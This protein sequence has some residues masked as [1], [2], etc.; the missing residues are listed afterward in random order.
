MTAARPRPRRV[1]P[2]VAAVAIVATVLAGGGMAKRKT[3]PHVG[4]VLDWSNR[5]VLYPQGA[6]LRALA[7]GER[8]PRA[9][10]N[11][12]RLIQ[13]A[14]R[15]TP[16]SY[17]ATREPDAVLG[18]D[19]RD[20]ARSREAP[21][22]LAPRRPPM[23]PILPVRPPNPEV[24]WSIALAGAG[25][26]ANMFPAKYS[27]DVNATPD[28]TGD[29]VVFA[30]NANAT[31][32]RANIVALN[33]LYSGTTSTSCG[34]NQAASVLW[35]YDAGT[36]TSRIRTSP[37]ISLD[38]TK[39]AFIDGNNPAVFHVLTPTAGQGTITVPATPT[40]AQIA[41]VTLTTGADSNGSPFVD[42]Y[43]DVAYVA[44]NNG[45]IFK[46]TGVFNGTPALAGAPWPLT[47]GATTLTEPVI[48][49]GTGNIFVGSANGRLYGFTPAGV[50]IPGSPVIIGSGL[51]NGG[52]T[53]APLVD[54][55]NGLIYVATGDNAAQVNAVVAQTRTSTFATVSTAA[56]GNTNAAV[57][58]AGAFND[59]YFNVTTNMTGTTSEW[60][61]YE[62]GVSTGALTNPVL[63][64]L[65]FNAA[66]QI[67]AAV[68]A[69]SVSLS[70]NNGEVCSPI[71]EFKNGVDR[72]F[73]SLLTSAQV[74]FFDV[75]TTT[76]PTLGGT[77]AV[78]PVPQTGGTSG[79]I[80]DNSNSLP[81]ASSIYFT[82]LATGTCFTANVVAAPNGATETGNVVTITTTTAHG[83]GVG[84]S[85]T[86]AGVLVGYNGAHVVTSVPS[87]TKFTYTSATTGLANDGGGTATASGFCAVKLTQ[88]GLQ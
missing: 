46:I 43:G 8:D 78:S 18:R 44:T 7:V 21:V 15:A 88:G 24:D 61:L 58:H 42:Y 62:C 39:V 3:A 77:G 51:A 48:D 82:R 50:A 31:A 10:W 72:L 76:T 57:I 41:D 25:T 71:T 49:F 28:C 17:E 73:L 30:V 55:V 23:R 75:S 84:E 54:V 36:G 65:G 67:N 16:A 53:D 80:V 32:A 22:I 20:S 63:Y 45:R 19:L 11:Y 83:F 2:A 85:V 70:A 9:Y 60:F 56:I 86:L 74:E 40:P 69:T 29:F 1:L 38:G 68:D 33:N 59:A 81:Q 27:F 52:I 79:I 35:A 6:S 12:L 13:A 37:I 66:R 5:H 34:T 87:P 26:A 47:A 14:N 4:Q 64:R